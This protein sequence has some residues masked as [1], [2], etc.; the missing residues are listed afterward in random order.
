[1][2]NNLVTCGLCGGIGHITFIEE[3]KII[4]EDCE[5]CV[6]HGLM[7]TPS[8][9]EIKQTYPYTLVIWEYGGKDYLFNIFLL[10]SKLYGVV[11]NI[12]DNNNDI[13][14]LKIKIHRKTNHKFKPE[15]E[16]KL[17][18]RNII[19]QNQLEYKHYDIM[20]AMWDLLPILDMTKIT[21][22]FD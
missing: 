20:P 11:L 15:E 1:M 4:K 10:R 9:H 5:I 2:P 16:T 17:L 3:N 18:Q 19:F 8:Y 22:R 13:I 6:S 7:E 21:S 14:L 12:H